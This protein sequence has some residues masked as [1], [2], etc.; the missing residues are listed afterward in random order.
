MFLFDDDDTIEFFLAET[1]G[2]PVGVIAGGDRHWDLTTT[3]LGAGDSNMVE[4]EVDYLTPTFSDTLTAI[5]LSATNS[6]GGTFLFLPQA[7]HDP[8]SGIDELTAQTPTGVN[9]QGALWSDYDFTTAAVTRAHSNSNFLMGL[10][11]SEIVSGDGDND[12]IYGLLGDDTLSGGDGTDILSGGVG[13]DSLDGEQVAI[14]FGVGRATTPWTD[15]RTRI[16]SMAAMGPT[17]SSVTKGQ[18]PCW[19]GADTTRFLV[20]KGMTASSAT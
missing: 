18:I 14:L 10:P 9:V 1:G 5:K 3:D 6:A 2:L 17:V 12:S 13:D 7:G 19:G 20:V 11:Y 8:I 4:M 15:T 16:W